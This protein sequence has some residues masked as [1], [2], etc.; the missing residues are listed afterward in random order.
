LPGTLYRTYCTVSALHS[1]VV[2]S[3]YN[4]VASRVEGG[5][6]NVR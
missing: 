2:P 3:Q 4:C 1:T 6:S 5:Y